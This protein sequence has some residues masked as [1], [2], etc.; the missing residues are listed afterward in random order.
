MNNDNTG[1]ANYYNCPAICMSTIGMTPW[2]NDLVGSPS[3]MSFVPNGL[4]P[5]NDKMDLRERLI[6]I[7]FS[8]YERYLLY[9]RYIPGQVNAKN[10]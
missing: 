6:N 10:I 7:A 8:L 1:F 9:S 3:P 4:L 5:Y 2:A